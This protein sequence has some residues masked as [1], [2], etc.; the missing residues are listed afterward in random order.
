MPSCFW[1]LII[2]KTTVRFSAVL[3]ASHVDD[4]KTNFLSKV[5]QPLLHMMYVKKGANLAVLPYQR[6]S[7]WLS[8][9]EYRLCSEYSSNYTS[10]NAPNVVVKLR[11]RFWDTLKTLYI[12]YRVS[13][14]RSLPL[15]SFRN[16]R[17]FIHGLSHKPFWT[18]SVHEHLERFTFEN[19]QHSHPK[20]TFRTKT[21]HK[22][23]DV[24]PFIIQW[25]HPTNILYL[26]HA[27]TWPSTRTKPLYIFHIQ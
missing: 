6:K 12:Y 8:L 20:R 17:A 26:S 16:N 4:R 10:S 25:I 2:K 24:F 14:L 18:I 9:D 1:T 22:I 27:K 13:R 5:L 3:L 11:L 21:K 19:A 7:M 23:Y 15:S